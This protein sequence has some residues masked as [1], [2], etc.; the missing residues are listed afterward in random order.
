[1]KR[2]IAILSLILVL[3]TSNFFA[4]TNLKEYKVGHVVSVSLPDYMSRTVDVNNSSII[5]YKSTVK[6]V[7]GFII[8]D[9][10]EE[11]ALAEINYSSI[12]EFCED[13]AKDF[14][15]DEKKRTFTYPEYQKKGDI[16]FAEYDATYYDKEAK[17]EIY[18][19]VGIVETKTS[20]YKVLSYT[21][22]ENKDKFKA[23]FQSI[24]YSLKD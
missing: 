21:S 10:K 15:K 4:Q 3:T 20:Y 8:E 9:N 24:L 12:N 17:A 1:M 11:L 2:I 18:Y 14:L 22:K 19:L 13:F 6:D 7:Y 16:N 5:Q 23:D